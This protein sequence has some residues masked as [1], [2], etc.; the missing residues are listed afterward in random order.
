MLLNIGKKPVTSKSGLLTT[1]TCSL[2]EE[3]VKYALEGS[4]FVIYGRIR[5]AC[6]RQ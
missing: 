3:P 2:E 6:R 5:G 1:L 4:I